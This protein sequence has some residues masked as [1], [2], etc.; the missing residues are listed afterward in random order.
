MVLIQPR[1]GI[2]N[3]GIILTLASIIIRTFNEAEFLDDVLEEVEEQ[4][5]DGLAHEVILVDSGSDDGT[6]EIAEDYGCR[7]RYIS[8]DDF[9]FGR[10][11]NYGCEATDGD[12]L[13]FLSGHCVPM[14]ERWLETLVSPILDGTV[15]YAYGK[16]RGGGQTKYSERKLFEKHYPEHDKIP[17]EGR[18][19][20]N[21][22]AALDPDIWEKFGGFDE[23]VTGLE[24]MEMASRLDESGYDIGYV[25]EAGVRH[26]HHETWSQV[27]WRYE[28]EAI[29]LQKIMPQVQL[30]FLDFLRYSMAGVFHDW[31]EA[32][33][34]GK[35]HNKAIEIVQFRLMQYWGSYRGNDQLRELSKEQKE[36]YFYPR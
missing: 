23:E 12:V 14:H 20:N 11:L 35:F 9:T 34:E 22:N 17:Q 13:V 3:G 16:Q 29:A 25:S 32:L 7:V 1:P 21:A 19:C 27:R 36:K 30:N 31:A 5:A 15:A 4:R 8:K 2:A 24:D 33:N 18:F 26:H 28:R 6:L 10:S